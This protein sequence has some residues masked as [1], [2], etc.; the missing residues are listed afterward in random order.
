[1]DPLTTNPQRS[2]WVWL[3]SILSEDT[4]HGSWSRIQG[5]LAFV[6]AAALTTLAT[7]T[8]RD[9]PPGAQTVLLGLLAA[10]GVGYTSNVA[11]S[12]L[13]ARKAPQEDA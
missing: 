6:L 13:A 7:W 3:F 10:A 11:S 5:A 9:I 1:M 2:I 12:V 4:G 8:G